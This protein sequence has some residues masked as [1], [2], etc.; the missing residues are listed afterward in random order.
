MPTFNAN[1]LTDVIPTIFAQGL[2]ALREACVM[3]RLVNSDYST[4]TAAK[5]DVVNVPIPSAISVIDV[6]PG[7]YATDPAAITPTKAAISLDYWREAAFFLTDS[8]IAKAVSGIVPMQVSE[9]IRSLADDVN[10]KL[11]ALYK[12]VYGYIGT[13]GTTPFAVDTKAAQDARKTLNKQI[14]PV[15]PRYMV[16]DAD[17]DGNAMG[18]RAFQDASFRGDAGGIVNGQIGA[19]LGFR[20]ILMDQAVPTHTCGT[21]TDGTAHRALFNGGGSAQTV[22]AKTMN[23]DA[24]SLSGTVLPGDVFTVAGDTQTYVITNTTTKT[25]AANA[26]TGLTFEPGAK[27]AW[28]DD[29]QVTFKDSHVANLAF[30]RD[31]FALAVRMLDDQALTPGERNLMISNTDPVSGLALRLEVRREHKRVRWSFDILYGVG[32][33]RRECAVRIAG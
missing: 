2:M 29:A 23:V 5:G 28:A 7:P 26:I 25:A 13:A 9:A 10:A 31:A 8:D 15:D 14:C 4:A 1:T 18:L 20:G 19:K 33:V 11:F 21:L 12:S 17:A 16:L 3:P 6:D 30:H 27:V 32:I 22:G 24:T